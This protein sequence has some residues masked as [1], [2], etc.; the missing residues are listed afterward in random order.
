MFV[1][2]MLNKM[3]DY[4]HITCMFTCCTVSSHGH[5]FHF[6]MLRHMTCELVICRAVLY[7]MDVV[8]CCLSAYEV[9]V[10]IDVAHYVLHS[11][12]CVSAC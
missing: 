10:K 5:G 7:S 9:Q 4:S 1:Y 6:P 11:E 8:S 2:R 12:M 3:K